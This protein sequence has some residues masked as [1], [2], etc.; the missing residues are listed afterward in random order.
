LRIERGT[1]FYIESAEPLSDQQLNEVS[2]LLHDRMVE[3]VF[4]DL[5]QAKTLFIQHQPAPL[6]E[7]DIMAG[8][9]K[10]LKEANISLG[11]ALADDEID[12]LV[13][14][15]QGLGRNPTDAELMMFAQ[16]N[17]EHCRHKIFQCQLDS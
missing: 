2:D 13:A 14:S 15:F 10:A 11:L 12:Y 6:T 8:G 3:T 4:N 17:S 16:A 5:Q 7:V 9:V 1:A